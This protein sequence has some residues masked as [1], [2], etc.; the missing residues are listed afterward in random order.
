M[1][2]NKRKAGSLGDVSGDTCSGGFALQTGT[3]RWVDAVLFQLVDVTLR[4]VD[5]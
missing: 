5:H 4:C 2:G 1:Y 3:H